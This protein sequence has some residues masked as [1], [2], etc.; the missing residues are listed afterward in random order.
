L[1]GLQGAR[2]A[3]GRASALLSLR[4]A[5]FA[6]LL[7]GLGA[8]Y[9]GRESLRNLSTNLDVAF[10]ALVLI[11]AVFALVW[12]VLPLWRAR[13]LFAVGLAFVLLAVLCREAGFEI[14]ANFAKLGA[15]TALAFWFLAYFETAAWVLL[16][17]AIIPWVDAYSVF[18][19]PTKHIVTERPEVFTLLSFAFPV[20]GEHGAANLGLPDLLFFALFLAASVRFSLRPG[21][22]WI[23]MVASFGV[24]MAV[25]VWWDI[26]GLPA[27]PLL[28]LGFVLPNA[29][30][31]WR[32]LQA[33]RR[34]AQVDGG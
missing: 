8:Y 33:S 12:L 28:S 17:A 27:L 22:T 31:L 32:E 23:A 11:P 19:G 34:R 3:L 10:L 25:A 20:P 14:S 13:G 7:A 16:V 24:T 2:T 30:L 4:V 21:W 29:D 9:V 26:G 5:A 1:A 6:A 15:T 18:K